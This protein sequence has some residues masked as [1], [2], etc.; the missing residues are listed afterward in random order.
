MAHTLD[1]KAT[2]PIHLEPLDLKKLQQKCLK[3]YLKDIADAEKVSII[4]DFKFQRIAS[5]QVHR[6]LS[7][8]SRQ[9]LGRSGTVG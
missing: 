5:G 8:S 4:F 6:E 1:P 7:A 3:D 2:K 9:D